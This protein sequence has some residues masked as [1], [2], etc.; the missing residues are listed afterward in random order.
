MAD[1]DGTA[2]GTIYVPV[3]LSSPWR[4][5]T[6]WGTA[7]DE[8]PERGCGRLRRMADDTPTVAQARRI[9][10]D[11]MLQF[12]VDPELM[13]GTEIDALI[14]AVRAEQPVCCVCSQPTISGGYVCDVCFAA[15]RPR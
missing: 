15:P 4:W 12:I 10:L 6:P 9:L 1:D 3:M 11:E 7:D 5:Q 2:T 8:T 14:A 13:V